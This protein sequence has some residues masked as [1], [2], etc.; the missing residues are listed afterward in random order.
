MILSTTISTYYPPK[1]VRALESIANNILF[2]SP[3]NQK[4][5]DYEK[6]RGTLLLFHPFRNEYKEITEQ[7]L[8]KKYEKIEKDEV[9]REKLE[10]QISFFQ[11]FQNI[12]DD[13]EAYIKEQE[14]EE[15]E[16]NNDYEADNIENEDDDDLESESTEFMDI[17]L[18][19][20]KIKDIKDFIK[21]SKKEVE[22]ETGLM[23]K[24]ALLEKICMLN[25]QQ[26]QIFDDIISRLMSGTF[27][28]NQFLLYISGDAGTGKSFLFN[29]I[30]HA[31]KHIL[32]EEGDTLDQPRV[33]NLAPSKANYS[34]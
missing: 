26:R 30:I 22:R 2:F 24:K 4:R 34:K 23:D 18:E 31:A 11:P 1:N 6:I 5:D 7:D 17:K 16:E 28:D 20:T 27:E 10:S 19:T 32:R 25:L 3:A 15:F 8:R 29:T 9:Q 33:L 14:D 13:I 12:L 21:E